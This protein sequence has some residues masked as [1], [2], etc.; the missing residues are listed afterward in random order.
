MY[1]PQTKLTKGDLAALVQEYTKDLATKAEVEAILSVALNAI[2][3]AMIGGDTVYLHG[4]GTFTPRDVPARPF[5][6]PQTG[7]TGQTPAHRRVTFK[8]C[9][10]FLPG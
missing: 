3:G 5:R 6:N 9:K 2:R 7:E 10:D 4:F 1:R 8:P